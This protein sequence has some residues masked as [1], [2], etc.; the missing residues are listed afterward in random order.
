MWRTIFSVRWLAAAILMIAAYALPSTAAAHSGHGTETH[1]VSAAQS[2]NGHVSYHSSY[3]AR[4]HISQ[5][6]EAVSAF[7]VT[8]QSP[9]RNCDGLCCAASCAGC[10]GSLV[11]TPVALQPTLTGQQKLSGRPDRRPEGV[12]AEA[13]PRPPQSFV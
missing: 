2:L 7:D 10:C 1:A 3:H 12:S 13:L 6:A 8:G 5:S 4:Q 11:M 9:E